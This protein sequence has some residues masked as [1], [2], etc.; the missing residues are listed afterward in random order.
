MRG[1][2]TNMMLT[3]AFALAIAP[4]T[5][6]SAETYVTTVT[7]CKDNGSCIETTTVYTVDAWGNV[8]VI[9]Q[10]TR[11]FQRNDEAK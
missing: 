9:S 11:V 1:F 6:L 10:T 8:K 7:H 3:L 5:A 4:G 2:T